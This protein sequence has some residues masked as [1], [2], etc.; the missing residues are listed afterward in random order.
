MWERYRRET[1]MLLLLINLH[2]VPCK[3][4]LVGLK[5]VGIQ[6]CWVYDVPPCHT[7]QLQ[8]QG[9]NGGDNAGQVCPEK[10]AQVLQMV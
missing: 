6:W 3:A 4:V 1:E 2:R 7:G 9:F 5:N 10:L 8:V